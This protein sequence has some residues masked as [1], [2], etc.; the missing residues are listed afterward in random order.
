MGDFS[1]I[2]TDLAFEAQESFVTSGEAKLEGVTVSEYVRD[3]FAITRTTVASETASS[4]L[5]KPKGEYVTIDLNTLLKREENAFANCVSVVSKMIKEF[6]GDL[7]KNSAVLVVGLGNVQITPDAIGPWA[8]DDVLVT[9]HLKDFKIP[10]FAELQSVAAVKTDVLG[11]TG[12]ESA[13]IVRLLCRELSPAL[14]I[15]VDA[16]A[17]R[18]TSRLC[19]TLQITNTGISPGSGV[20]NARAELSEKTLAVSVIAIGAPTV[21]DAQTLAHELGVAT[22]DDAQFGLVVTPRDIDSKARD[23]AKVIAYS[24]NSAL[25]PE[26]ELED[27]DMLLS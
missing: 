17:A 12:V 11:N 16:L 1:K 3:G 10:D 18:D 5:C 27:F 21:V 15:A 2:R 8:V 19:T 24:I 7:P 20:G 22:A 26:L 4:A 13:Q 25:H 14:V 9:K 6:S 23:L